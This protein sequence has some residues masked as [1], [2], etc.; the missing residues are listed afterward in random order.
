VVAVHDQGRTRSAQTGLSPECRSG[1][2][3][4]LRT[5]QDPPLATG[6]APQ[7]LRITPASTPSTCTF[8]A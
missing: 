1:A 3:I 5:S 6:G 2:A 7:H 4:N 8:L